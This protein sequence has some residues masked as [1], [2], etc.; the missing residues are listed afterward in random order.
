LL[1][2]LTQWLRR[3]STYEQQQANKVPYNYSGFSHERLMANEIPSPFLE[4]KES[5][6][7]S[8]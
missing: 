2:K 5:K 8:Q 7:S 6:S 4:K 1:F 3:T